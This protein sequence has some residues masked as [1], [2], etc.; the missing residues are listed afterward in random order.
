MIRRPRA[1]RKTTKTVE[2]QGTLDLAHLAVTAVESKKGSAIILLDIHA[3]SSF[4]DYFLICNGDSE[5]QI[6]AIAGGVQEALDKQG[7]KQLGHEGSAESGWV[8]L[9][10]GDLLIHIFEPDKRNYYQLEDLWK[11]AQTVV[12]VQ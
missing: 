6:K 4:T 2:P 9:D 5:R 8:L 7:M 1:T 12:K 3:L 11:D 10:Y